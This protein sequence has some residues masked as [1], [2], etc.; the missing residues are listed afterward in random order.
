MRTNPVVVLTPHLDQHLRFR[1][2]VEDLAVQQFIPQLPVE[3]LHVPVLPRA[4]RFDEQC[5]HA[6]FRQPIPYYSSRELRA[7][8]AADVL[9]HAPRRHQPRQPLEHIVTRQLP[10]HVDRQTLPRV[11]IHDRQHLQRHAVVRATAHKIVRPHVILPL[12]TQ[13]H[14]AAIVQPQPSPFRLFLRHFQAFLSPHPLNTLVVYH[15]ALVSQ[16]RRDPRRAVAAI[17]RRQFDQPSRQWLF[18]FPDLRRMPLRPSGLAQHSACSAFANVQFFLDAI[19]RFTPTRRAQKFGRAAS[20]RIALSSSASA[21]RRFRRAF[22]CSNSF[23][24][25][26]WSTFRPPYSFRQRKYVWSV[27]P[28]TLQ[29]AATV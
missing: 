17:H 14:A 1:Q 7:V 11:L 18:I 5:L 26:A 6:Y 8:V 23:H 25:L 10:G 4:A 29:T 27:I 22:S 28:I 12:W 19:H 15:P 3:A 13:P 24:R 21:S 9:R 2:T 20:R 16:H